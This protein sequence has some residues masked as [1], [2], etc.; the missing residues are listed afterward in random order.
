MGQEVEV[1]PKNAKIIYLFSSFHVSAQSWLNESDTV[2]IKDIKI[3]DNKLK[4]TINKCKSWGGDP[5]AGMK[6]YVK[7]EKKDI[8]IPLPVL[9]FH[10]RREST[11][12]GSRESE[13]L[14]LYTKDGSKQ[15]WSYYYDG[16]KVLTGECPYCGLY[17]EE[18]D[19]DPDEI[20]KEREKIYTLL[21]K[22]PEVKID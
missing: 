13:T 1:I 20:E 4:I 11:C 3:E 15:V 17:Y 21:E 8:L 2:S 9:I 10:S 18:C 19:C 16:F 6:G 14:V 7:E 12:S 22:L 5:G